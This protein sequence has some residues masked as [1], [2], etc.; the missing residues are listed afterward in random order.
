[1]PNLD[2]YTTGVIHLSLEDYHNAGLTSGETKEVIEKISDSI[3]GE[4][5]NYSVGNLHCE[6]RY[7]NGNWNVH[8]RYTHYE[9]IE[10]IVFKIKWAL[11]IALERKTYDK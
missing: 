1:M 4:P 11:D 8:T 9:D 10:R 5:M 3:P 6:P 2:Y 7:I